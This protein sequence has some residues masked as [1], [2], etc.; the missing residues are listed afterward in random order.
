MGGASGF[1]GCWMEDVCKA[2]GLG[3]SSTAACSYQSAHNGITISGRYC[4]VRMG[5]R[6]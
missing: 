5:D 3:R 2:F 1:V 6:Q 4:T